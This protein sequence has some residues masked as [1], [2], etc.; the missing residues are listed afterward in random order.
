MRIAV[1]ADKDS[2]LEAPVS[3]HFGRCPYYALVDLEGEAVTSVKTV[4]NPYYP[5]HVPGV[6]PEFIHGRARM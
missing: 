4:P 1:S 6:V 3:P 5:D 2:G